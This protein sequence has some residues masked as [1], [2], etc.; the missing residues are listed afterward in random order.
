MRSGG[1]QPM[2]GTKISVLIVDDDWPTARDLPQ[3]LTKL[4]YHT[5]AVTASA[6]EAVTAA[7]ASS[8]DVALV[9]IGITGP[10]N[11]VDIAGVLRTRFNIPVVFLTS[12]SD[13]VGS[14][15]AI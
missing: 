1:G 2:P 5:C 4:G 8:P 12:E 14:M 10:L 9:S 6:E 3:T 13:S 15:R 7:T 11:G